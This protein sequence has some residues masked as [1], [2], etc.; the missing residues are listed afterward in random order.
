MKIVAKRKSEALELDDN[1]RTIRDL[2][3]WNTFA[4]M[5][6]DEAID[7]AWRVPLY[8]LHRTKWIDSDQRQ[9]GDQYYAAYQD[10]IDQHK[11]D[12]DDTP[13]DETVKPRIKRAKKR[14]KEIVGLLG[15][16][17]K[18]LDSL[19]ISEEHL[20]E[21]EKYI[22]RDALTLLVYFFRL[23]NKQATKKV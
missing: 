11:K 20:T 16:R 19:I 12:P 8:R 14:W 21:R 7:R 17:K 4:K 2:G 22:A 9:A 3:I 15:S 5:V 23:G 13:H 1:P 10:F 18:V 6:E